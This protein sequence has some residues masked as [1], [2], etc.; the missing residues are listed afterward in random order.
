VNMIYTS[1]SIREAANLLASWTLSVSTDFCGL[2]FFT[3]LKIWMTHGDLVGRNVVLL[4]SSASFF[5]P[6]CLDQCVIPIGKGSQDPQDLER[7]SFLLSPGAK[8]IS[9][10]FC[11]RTRRSEVLSSSITQCRSSVP[12]THHPSTQH[13]TT[14]PPK[15]A[16]PPTQHHQP[17]SS[18]TTL[19]ASP[20]A[21]PS[22]PANPPP[23]ASP[24]SIPPNKPS[25]SATRQHHGVPKTS[26][27]R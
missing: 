27:S 8:K 21:P 6:Q 23:P 17:K 15:S 1:C 9:S 13:P 7:H 14:P 20:S 5:P 12:S 22:K 3:K 16:L 18:N 24:T 10:Q 25:V 11:D 4:S 26:T 19:A 2:H